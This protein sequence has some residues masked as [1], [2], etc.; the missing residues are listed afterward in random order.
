MNEILVL[1]AIRYPLKEQGVR[2]LKRAIDL[3]A[4]Q[5]RADLSIL[6]INVIHRNEHVTQRDL[7][8]AVEQEFGPLTNAT[9]YVRDSFLLEE[10]ILQE[11]TQQ[12]AEYVVIG[13]D[14]RAWWRRILT[15]RLNMD[16]DLEAFLQRHLNTNLIVV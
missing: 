14:T 2:T 4:D 16:I 12:K 7:K 6:H 9:Y 10:A 1:V 5:R 3:A 8:R 13:K 15:H 11:A